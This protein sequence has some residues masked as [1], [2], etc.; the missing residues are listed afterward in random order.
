MCLVARF[1]IGQVRQAQALQQGA[2]LIVQLG[3]SLCHL[4]QVAAARGNVHAADS[5][6]RDDG[7]CHEQALGS[8]ADRF[9]T[10]VDRRACIQL[11]AQACCHRSL[12]NLQL[13][14]PGVLLAQRR[15]VGGLDPKA[16]GV[17][18]Q[19]DG[20]IAFCG[21]ALQQRSQLNRPCPRIG[22]L[23][24]QHAAVVFLAC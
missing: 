16:R 21:R 14:Q 15:Q 4:S 12:P 24:V 6:D 22:H 2:V 7:R 13:V 10:E 9:V 20:A 1:G 19:T 8:P 5:R 17:T 3:L 11:E 18:F 23:P